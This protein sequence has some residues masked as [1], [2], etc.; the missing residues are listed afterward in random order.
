MNNE[1]IDKL[2][3]EATDEILG[4]DILDKKK[5][6]RLIVNECLNLVDR[7]EVFLVNTS[8]PWTAL[9]AVEEL[10][11]DIREHFGIDE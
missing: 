8:S 1:L 6:A 11:D 7:W 5:F 3:A 9:G 2:V 10:G 4:V